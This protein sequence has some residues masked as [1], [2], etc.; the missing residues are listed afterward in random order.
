MIVVTHN[1]GNDDASTRAM[2]YI[3]D[4]LFKVSMDDQYF[5]W[6]RKTSWWSKRIKENY[7]NSS[8]K[9]E[10]HQVFLSVV[11]QFLKDSH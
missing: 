1:Q 2:K 5:W 6:E 9:I 10:P 11:C 7:L 4:F 3:Q 8:I